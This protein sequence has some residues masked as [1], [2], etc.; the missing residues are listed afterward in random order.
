[1]RTSTW[2]WHVHRYWLI[3]DLYERKT[4]HSSSSMRSSVN[5][6][7]QSDIIW[8]IAVI[9]SVFSCYLLSDKIFQVGK[10]NPKTRVKENFFS[11][12]NGIRNFVSEIIFKV[13]NIVSIKN[14]ESENIF[15]SRKNRKVTASNKAHLSYL[16]L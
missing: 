12:K 11:R 1:M 4:R 15:L 10:T 5:V 16:T 8:C 7:G 9:F 3:V 6:D 13:Q 14:Q 2:P